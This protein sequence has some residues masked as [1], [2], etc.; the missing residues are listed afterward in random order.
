MSFPLFHRPGAVVFLDDDPDYLEMLAMVLPRHWHIRLFLRPRTCINQLQQEPPQWEA[1]AWAQQEII[2]NWRA[3]SPLIPQILQYWSTRSD[4]YG[5]THV[6]VFDYAMPGMDGLQAL[7]ELTD[8]PG[9]RVLLTG[10]ADEHVAVSAFNRGLIDQFIAKQ[11]PDISQHLISMVQRM[12]DRPQL[13]HTQTWRAALTQPQQAL[14]Q[15]PSVARQLTSVATDQWVEY[16]VIGEPF[17]ILGMNAEGLVSWLQ[18]EP[19]SGL[20][21]LA[22]LAESQ[23]MDA[24]CAADI[25][26]GQQLVDLELQQALKR[27][28]PPGMAPAFSIGHE[29]SM[30]AAMFPLELPSSE[31]QWTG[32]AKWLKKNGPRTVQD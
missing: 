26:N 4:P 12:L 9:G 19:A 20:A 31:R 3:G 18:L 23:G 24:N 21:E 11:T 16:V 8:W 29:G 13:R 6:C 5:F 30:L 22:E 10:Q 32:Y 27:T 14:L 15:V 1:D 17:G 7:S 2:D 25:R 28:G